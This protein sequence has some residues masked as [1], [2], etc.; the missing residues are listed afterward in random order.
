MLCSC[1]ISGVIHIKRIAAVGTCAVIL[2]LCT[3]CNALESIRGQSSPPDFVYED[4]P[5]AEQ[6]LPPDTSDVT[7]INDTS[8]A[9]YTAD[10]ADSSSGGRSELATENTLVLDYV[11]DR[12]FAITFD[13]F[14]LTATGYC[15]E[16][17]KAFANLYVDG[18][19]VDVAASVPTDSGMF[20]IR[21]EAEETAATNNVLV[22]I[23]HDD[24]AEWY[25]IHLTENGFEAP[26]ASDIVKINSDALSAVHN[27]PAEGV[28]EYICVD[29]DADAIAQTLDLVKEVS[30]K[31]CEGCSDDYS[32]LRALSSW[33]SNNIYYD[34]DALNGDVTDDTVTLGHVLETHRT[35]CIGFANLFA[36]LC[37]AQ[38]ITCYTVIGNTSISDCFIEDGAQGELHNWNIAVIDGR[39][40]IV[41]TVWDTY[42][43]YQYGKYNSE[44]VIE[45]FFD[46]SEEYFAQEHKAS[47]VEH[48]DYFAQASD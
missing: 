39:Y 17:E 44:E 40:V 3:G 27:L 33:V 11:P 21:L 23:I 42:N 48:R 22:G 38:D 10:T 37:E 32:R 34:F 41:D 31:I 5:T 29:G 20:S 18:T 43:N 36:A 4:S 6:T 28:S 45:K 30:D 16:P 26:D 25:H 9:P 14:S 46:V 2:A 24:I 19:C 15:S 12:S 35:V 8:D 13:G 7:D 47:Y 1:K